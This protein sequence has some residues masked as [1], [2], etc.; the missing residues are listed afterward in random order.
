MLFYIQSARKNNN[1]NNNK[2]LLSFL[3]LPHFFPILNPLIEKHFTLNRI[4]TQFLIDMSVIFHVLLSDV[5]LIFK[6]V[7]FQVL[8]YLLCS[9]HTQC[10][11]QFSFVCI[12]WYFF[13][14]PKEHSF[15]STPMIK[16]FCIYSRQRSRSSFGEKNSVL[17]TSLSSVRRVLLWCKQCLAHQDK[18]FVLVVSKDS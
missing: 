3:I 2:L 7:L 17:P 18:C 14:P 5:C 10:E 9:P 12:Q 16:A 11:L 4:Y 13:F 6:C 8:V 1:N 15:L